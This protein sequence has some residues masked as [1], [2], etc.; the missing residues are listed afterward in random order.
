MTARYPLLYRSVQGIAIAAVL[1]CLFLPGFMQQGQLVI[2][3]VLI[4]L[5]GIPHGATDYLIFQHLSR[6]LW[7]SKQMARFYLTYL[8]LMAGYALLW[9]LAP[10][11]ALALFLL[12]SIYH[13]GQSNWNY[14]RF[15][16]R[17]SAAVA[18]LL[19][20]SFVLLTPIVWQLNQ[21]APIIESIVG[22]EIPLP[23]KP[24]REAF[25][26]ALFA[27]NLWLTVYYYLQ[28]RIGHRAFLNELLNFFVLALLFVNAPLL[29]AF[30]LY[31]VGWHS[32]SSMMDQIRFFRQ[33]LEKYAVKDYVKNALP[34]SLAAIASL[35]L[36]AL[37]QANMAL[38]LNI[39]MIFVFISVITLPHM[40]LIDQLYQ[41][42]EE[43]S[44]K[45][46]ASSSLEIR[47]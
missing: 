40:L 42:Q 10:V 6:P 12:I 24:W 20:G 2:A 26:I 21:A 25:C 7:G 17:R 36:L 43:R 22:V 37:V 34:L 27:A 47:C 23:P 18:Y 41:E 4:L 44:E 15:P 11:M 39:G 8:S 38:P 28:Q 31:F 1:S 5:I 45:P 14:A 3:V 13:F 9:Y 29:L 32:L 46:L 19:W 33:R 16:S 35:G 30:T